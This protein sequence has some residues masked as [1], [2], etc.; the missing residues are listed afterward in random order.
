M[1]N[2]R[3]AASIATP[4][5]CAVSSSWDKTLK[6]WDLESGRELRCLVGHSDPDNGVAVSLDGLRALSASWD[7]MLK[8]WDLES[9][10]ELQTLVGHFDAVFGVALSADGRQ[11]VSASYDKTLRVWDPDAGTIT[12]TFTCDGPAKGCA[13]VDVRKIFAGD[14][15]GRVHFLSLELKEDN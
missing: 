15:S 13:F 1:S 11:V 12:A 9:G 5:G 2:P 8:L 7:N 4:R 3:E 10:R 14:E 6:V